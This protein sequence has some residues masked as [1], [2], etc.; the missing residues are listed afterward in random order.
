[1][2]YVYLPTDIK[3]LKELGKLR[4]NPRLSIGS[5]LILRVGIA[6]IELNYVWPIWYWKNDK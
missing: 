1:M 3:E 5:G 4:L 2:T 6:T